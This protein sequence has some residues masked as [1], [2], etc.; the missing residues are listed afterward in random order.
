MSSFFTAKVTDILLQS[1]LN[2]YLTLCI[3]G[4]NLGLA[5]MSAVAILLACL[6]VHC[7]GLC[8]LLW[9]I[10]RGMSCEHTDSSATFL[11]RQ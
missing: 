9:V 2:T 11:K 6:T 7:N 3:F 10:T 5:S 8:N 1:Q 4:L